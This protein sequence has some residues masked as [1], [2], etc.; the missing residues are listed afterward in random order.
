MYNMDK[1]TCIVNFH[2]VKCNLT[3]LKTKSACVP[4][5]VSGLNTYARGL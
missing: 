1:L 3:E 2:A 5:E 4:L